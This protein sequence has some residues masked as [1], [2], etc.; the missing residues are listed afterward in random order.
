MDK[1]KQ[2]IRRNN[3]QG[4]DS[5]QGHIVMGDRE[6][7]AASRMTSSKND[8]YLCSSMARLDCGLNQSASRQDGIAFVSCVPDTCC[9]HATR[10]GE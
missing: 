9:T 5:V 1:R 4:A 7:Q 6:Q 8:V 2:N 10:S 3:T